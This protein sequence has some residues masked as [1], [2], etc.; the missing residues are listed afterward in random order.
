MA[1]N[2]SLVDERMAREAVYF[3][4]IAR[5][6]SNHLANTIFRA[7]F[8]ENLYGQ[9]MLYEFLQIYSE[10]FFDERGKLIPRE[11]IEKYIEEMEADSKEWAFIKVPKKALE[12]T[13][14]ILND[15]LEDEFEIGVLEGDADA[16]DW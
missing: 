6:I 8:S 3:K 1:Y 7:V 5:Y 11:D 15:I 9:D 10:Y 12:P 4:K 2:K 14:E 13:I 16:N